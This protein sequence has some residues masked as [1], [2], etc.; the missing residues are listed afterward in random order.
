MLENAKN[1]VFFS[2]T[3]GFST[4]SKEAIGVLPFL[5][6]NISET[7]FRSMLESGTGPQKTV[8]AK[9]CRHQDLETLLKA[10]RFDC[11][12]QSLAGVETLVD[13]FIHS[14]H[15]KYTK[16]RKGHRR[17]EDIQKAMEWQVANG[18]IPPKSIAWTSNQ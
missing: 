10:V 12:K 8:I 18:V 16:R 15:D 2:E 14:I 4:K 5:H 1:E 6:M 17:M 11:N 7:T 9:A 3:S 13:A